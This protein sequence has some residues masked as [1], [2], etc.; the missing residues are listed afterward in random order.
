MIR[1]I[2]LV[3]QKSNGCVNVGRTWSCINPKELCSYPA[4]SKV[5]GWVVTARIIGSFDNN[6]F[7]GLFD[8]KEQ[9]IESM[10]R[11]SSQRYWSSK[12]KS[13]ESTWSYI[14]PIQLGV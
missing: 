4:L 12:K 9:M 5:S 10:V 3:K 8:S 2:Q 7:I 14:N 6:S 1:D 11:Q 13:K